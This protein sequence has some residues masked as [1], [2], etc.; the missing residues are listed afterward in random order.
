M[1]VNEA[2]VR[3]AIEDGSRSVGYVVKSFCYL[4]CQNVFSLI[5]EWKSGY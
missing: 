5:L 1:I 2:P 3:V 4:S